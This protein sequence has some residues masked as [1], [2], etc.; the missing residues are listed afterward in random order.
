M[1]ISE[2]PPRVTRGVKVVSSRQRVLVIRARQVNP[3]APP[4]LPSLGPTRR[5]S[6]AA[7]AARPSH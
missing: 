5:P 3:G 2:L 1:A 7:E 4:D 6:V